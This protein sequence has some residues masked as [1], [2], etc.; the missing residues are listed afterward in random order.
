MRAATKR[1]STTTETID[2]QA[3]YIAGRIEDGADEVTRKTVGEPDAHPYIA[4]VVRGLGAAGIT[5]AL[6]IVVLNQ[7]FTLDIVN[8]S[9]GPFDVSTVEGPLI[10]AL[11]LLAL[12]LL[13]GGARVVM[14]QMGGSNGGL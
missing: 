10:G 1:A 12:A 13:V 9:S 3:D 14:N 2:R 11:G 4:N 5:I 7:V 8:N 6:I